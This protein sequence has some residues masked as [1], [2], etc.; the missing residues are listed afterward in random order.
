MKTKRIL[1]LL[2]AVLVL[3]PWQAVYAET[4]TVAAVVR[5]GGATLLDA[6]DGNPVH[7]L[8]P[9]DM[10]TPVGKSADAG[11]V[12]VDCGRGVRLD[13]DGSSDSGDAGRVAGDGRERRTRQ[14]RRAAVATPIPEATPT[15]EAMTPDATPMPEPSSTVESPT[16]DT[17]SVTGR[18]LTEDSRLNVRAGPGL[19]YAIV[20]KAKPDERLTV[21]GVS[22]DGDGCGWNGATCPAGVVGS[23]RS[24]W[25]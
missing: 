19:D 10:V 22:R 2:A 5:S 23:R 7:A 17:A 14:A 25:R 18:V 13:R 12:A 15:P 21:T 1:V 16:T 8:R 20:G 6:P 3:L 9:G 24:M 4:S 11:W